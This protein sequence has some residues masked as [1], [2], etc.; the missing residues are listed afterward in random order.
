[1]AAVLPG[2]LRQMQ[3]FAAMR[4]KRACVHGQTGREDQHEPRRRQEARAVELYQ[5]MSLG[6]SQQSRS[7]SV[8]Q[9]ADERQDNM[10]NPEEV[11]NVG[12][13]APEGNHGRGS[14]TATEAESAAAP[15]PAPIP[16]P[17]Q[18]QAGRAGRPSRRGC[19][20]FIPATYMTPRGNRLTA[21][22]AIG[23]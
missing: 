4:F 16:R 8:G 20:M 2:L 14:A 1:M 15:Q 12:G 13:M 23:F 21:P 18:P 9:P 22:S 10:A 17:D 6:P 11:A 19:I 3:S 7:R 5:D